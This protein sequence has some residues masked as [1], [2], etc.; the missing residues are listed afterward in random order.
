MSFKEALDLFKTVSNNHANERD[1]LEALNS[2]LTMRLEERR[3]AERRTDG[4]EG[5]GRRVSDVDRRDITSR[6]SS[7]DEV[8]PKDS[9]L[10][11]FQELSLKEKEGVL[12]AFLDSYSEKGLQKNVVGRINNHDKNLKS[13]ARFLTWAFISFIVLIII[14]GQVIV[15]SKAPAVTSSIRNISDV[16]EF[17]FM[18][19]K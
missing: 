9:V 4:R 3:K 5:S 2:T 1:S 17:L 18:S 6:N 11:K 16:V 15:F 8:I 7:S 10:H 14:T 12:H 19:K 13:V